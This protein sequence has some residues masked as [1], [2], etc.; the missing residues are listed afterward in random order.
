MSEA[1]CLM[2]LEDGSE[3]DKALIVI[4]ALKLEAWDTLIGWVIEA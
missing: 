2:R 4:D 1:R 3:P